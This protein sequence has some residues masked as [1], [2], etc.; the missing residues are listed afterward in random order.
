MFYWFG[1]RELM[2][3][4]LISYFLTSMITRFRYGKEDALP[5][6]QSLSNILF[7]F[8][9]I[10]RLI[11]LITHWTLII[12]TP[13]AIIQG[14]NSS[15]IILF[16][17]SASLLIYYVPYIRKK[18]GP[19]GRLLPLIW[20]SLFF[21][22]L[23]SAYG[24]ISLL[25][26]QKTG[27]S[28]GMQVP[29]VQLTE[30]LSLKDLQGERIILNFWATWCPPCRTELPDFNSFARDYSDQIILYTVNLTE[31]EKSEEG[32]YQFLKENNYQLPLIM[33]KDG[34][35]SAAFNI[36]S[37]PTTLVINEEGRILHRQEGTVSLDF[38]KSQILIR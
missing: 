37:I 33:D 22:L 38:L 23:F 28:Q 19:R 6:N 8:L 15:V 24:F 12:Q 7:L 14:R 4:I 30:D 11:Y 18:K 32:V 13:M 35:L 16:A 1:L 29:P 21:A 36:K 34:S 10:N 27:V 17:L 31:T 9:G 20:I 25:N 2:I 5:L 3:L 26:R